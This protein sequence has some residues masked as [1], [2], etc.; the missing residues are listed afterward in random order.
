MVK[1][2][3]SRKPKQRFAP[4]SSVCWLPPTSFSCQNRYRDSLWQMVS[5]NK[6]CTWISLWMLK[7]RN[8][9]VF[10]S[11]FTPLLISFEQWTWHV[12][13]TD[14]ELQSSWRTCIIY[15]PANSHLPQVYHLDGTPNHA[16]SNFWLKKYHV[17]DS[18]KSWTILPYS[19]SH[20]VDVVFIPE[21][22]QNV[23]LSLWLYIAL[24]TLRTWLHA[25][26][27]RTAHL[28]TRQHHSL[29]STYW[30]GHFCM[31]PSGGSQLGKVMTA[32][33]PRR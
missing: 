20:I 5:R 28:Q 33:T 10:I 25:P 13:S 23:Q 22:P 15:V 12:Q 11:R 31:T 3:R 26:L 24:C 19:P 6:Y 9:S 7:G 21:Q 27:S 16:Q 4:S 32:G 8:L 30:W 17:F 1:P 29:F 18:K 2:S 14:T